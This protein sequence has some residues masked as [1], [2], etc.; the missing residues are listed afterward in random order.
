MRCPSS[1]EIFDLFRGKLAEERE[2]T[3]RSHIAECEGCGATSEWVAK[4][5]AVTA[6][7]PLPEPPAAVLE[8]AFE[9]VP[10][11][12]AT[13]RVPRRGWSLSQL[14]LDSLTQPL[15]AGVRGAA[16]TGR[17]LLYRADDADLDLE[18][19]ETPGDHPAFRVT[20][21]L[22]IPGSPP[23][24]DLFV[25]LWSHEAV[26]AHAAGDELGLFVFPEVPPGTYRLEVWVPGEGRGIRIEAL[27]LAA[28]PS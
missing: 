7:G 8:R 10:R 19:R 24:A 9:I 25:A 18:V 13:S 21:Q 27:E 14:V 12:P 17:R 1:E 5:L 11:Q 22:L 15:P 20:G 6:D 3:V 4:V 23:P 26:T 16:D 28:S 2:Q